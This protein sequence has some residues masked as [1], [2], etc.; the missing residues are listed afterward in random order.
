MVKFHF[1]ACT[2]PDVPMPF[3]EEAI[4]TPFYDSAPFVE[5]LLTIEIWVY[6]WALYSVPLIYVSALVPVPDCSEYSGL[7]I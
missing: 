1:L 7:V 4:F 5:Y 3:V 6:F 2:C